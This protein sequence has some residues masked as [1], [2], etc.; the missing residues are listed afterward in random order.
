MRHTSLVVFAGSF[1]FL[2]ALPNVPAN[3]TTVN[4]NFVD[5]GVVVGG[6]TVFSANLA[7][8]GLS[9]I[10]TITIT[11]ASFGTGGSPG[12]FSGFDLDALFLDRDGN[13]FSTG[14]RTAASSFSYLAGSVRPTSD[15]TMQPNGAHPGPLFG[16][17]NATTIDAATATL[18][19]PL[20]NAVARL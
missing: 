11:D 12:I 4:V 6:S 10:A 13:I 2:S 15:P 1:A 18:G 8:V 17:L 3:A 7:G 14:D 5:T 20:I 16:S 9:Q 19:E